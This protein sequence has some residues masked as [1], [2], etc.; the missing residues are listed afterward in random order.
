[1]LLYDWQP[2]DI[3]S[4]Y[5]RCRRSTDHPCIFVQLG[6]RYIPFCA[7]YLPAYAHCTGSDN[8]HAVTS[9]ITQRR[10]SSHQRAL[11]RGFVT[12]AYIDSAYCRCRHSTD[13]PCIGL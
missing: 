7:S 9:D 3:D 2:K 5:C 8:E 11:V 1:M 10:C 12:I 6:R 13:H 4:A